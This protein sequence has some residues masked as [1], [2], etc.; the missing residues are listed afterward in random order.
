VEDP[1]FIRFHLVEILLVKEYAD[2]GLIP[3]FGE[4][5]WKKDFSRALHQMSGEDARQAKRKFRKIWRQLAGLKHPRIY[6][7]RYDPPT[8]SQKMN[9]KNIVWSEL[10]NEA[11]KKER[12]A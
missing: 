5:E 6:G 9:R 3:P 4:C 8:R 11:I 7:N 12:R 2:R 10:M 1:F